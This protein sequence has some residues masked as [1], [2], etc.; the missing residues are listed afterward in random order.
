MDK[1]QAR[2]LIRETFENPFDKAR[3]TTFIKN[4]LN[5]IEEAPF[6]YQG[7]Y[8]PDSYKPFISKYER[9]GKYHDGEN[10]ID[11]LIVHLNRE[12]SIER[13]RT[14]QRNFVA[15]YLQGKYGSSNEKDA[16]LVAFVSPGEA[17]WRFSLVKMDY[18]FE[19]GPTGKMRV[20]EEFTPAR[21]WSFLVG[22]NEKS[23]TAQSRLVPI[24]SDD[25][26]DPTLAQLEEAFSIETVTKEFFLKYRDLFIRIKEALDQ[27]V[28]K[29]A[30]I[31]SDFE[32]KGVDT[33]NFAKKLLGQVVFLYFLQKKGWFGVERDAE[34]GTGSKHFLRE[35]FQG[36]HGKYVNFFNDILEPLFYEALRI[37]R[38]HDD[39][40][41]SRFDCKIPFL[42]GGLFD[43]INNYDWVHTD[44]HLPNELFSNGV[45]TKEGDIGD[46]IL[47]IFDRY[48]F[49]VRED[50]P[51]EK[52]VAVDPEMLGKVFENLLEVKDRKS[53]G[54]YYTPREIVHY[55]C[56]ESL[57]NY[58][59]TT[60]NTGSEAIIKANPVQQKLIGKPD[61]EQ[62]G[63]SSSAYK[64]SVPRNDI[65]EFIRKGESTIQN[66]LR[67]MNEG[68]E[69]RNYSYQ[70][71]ES[72]RKNAKR[73]DEA[74]ASIK[75]CDPAVGSGAFPVGMM[76][77][78]VKAREVLTPHIV[79]DPGRGDR[80]VAPTKETERSPYNFKR[81]CIQ[82]SLYGVDIDPG[83]V[84][85]AKLRLW[86]SLVVDEE[87]YETIK[88]LPNLEYKI[89]CGNSLLG[90]EKDLLN[91]KLFHELET[92]KPQ[93]FEETNPGKKQALKDRIDNLIKQIT[94]NDEHFDFEV[95]FSEVF[96]DKACSERGRR[97]G[98]DVVIANPPYVSAIEFAT[99]YNESERQ[100]LNSLFESAKGTYDL[101]VLF[102]EKGIRLL[103]KKGVLTFIN[104]NKYL[105]ARYALALREFILK[106]ATLERLV[107]IS[108]ISVFEQ[109]A[110]YP[111]I[112]FLA[113][114][115]LNSYPIQLLLPKK[116]NMET[117]NLGNF[118]LS[119]V[120]SQL[121]R[122]L[123]ENIWG[124][125]LS[126]K[127]D[128]LQKLIEN[129]K[130][131][132]SLGRINAST[133]AS[134]ADAY[135]KHISN[136]PSKNSLKVV[137]TGTIEP[138]VSLWGRIELKH[139]GRKF[140]TPYLSI[141]K[142]EINR[143][144]L[145]LYK[146]PK[147]IFAKMAKR[148]EALLDELGEYAALNTNFFYDPNPDVSLKF[149]TAFCNSS[150]F[151]FF[152]NQ[153]FGALR[154]SGGYYQFQAPQLRVIPCKIPSKTIQST[155][156]IIVD[157]I[158]SITKDDDYIH[159]PEKQAKVKQY[160]RQIDQMVYELY[161]LTPEEIAIVESFIKN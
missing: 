148:C 77:E 27:V 86:L 143:R 113:R 138:F 64:Q 123:P 14:M 34:W 26:H 69:T 30:R 94:N 62:L 100:N 51:L 74:L 70:L 152:Y 156:D 67:V 61:P 48:N 126:D 128:L 19:Q 118:T 49:T 109:A 111:V 133:T 137:N 155:F 72:I 146:M 144:R 140:L 120:N 110:V 96:H 105:S 21:R 87:D 73:I 20:K 71:P 150:L 78:I 55:M 106:H 112:T 65:E 124:F 6:T 15:G 50:E 37:D 158:L 151:M 59:D 42:N 102:L 5:R 108:G 4:L 79:D 75:V 3:F 84:E 66:D 57:I 80:P 135:G 157:Q 154:M 122:M 149:I 46:G 134:E 2:N 29:D 41:Y 82:E 52:E 8:I 89:V 107:D 81:H 11:I 63:L 147:I 139:S 13:A 45:R 91:H 25:V 68:R 56:Q 53:K 40:Y 32:A 47:D 95:Y 101:Y 145:E 141:D 117:F 22:V 88:P 38:R 121:L 98:F 23:H 93:F 136:K 129:T 18:K 83:A 114:N 12:T 153:F 125:V 58:L 131:M 97:G 161:G 24:L 10:R 127:V 160:E 142:A 60:L 130:P 44:I 54:T 1:Q 16:A 115:N 7:Q 116:R 99:L 132:S 28:E 17:D 159:S 9:I 104:P 92:L 103:A 35:L 76:Q 36:R 90:V 85:I 43:P 31:R 33:V 39:D 119:S